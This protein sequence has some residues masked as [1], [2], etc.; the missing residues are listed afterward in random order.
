MLQMHYAKGDSLK[1][2][3]RCSV[4]FPFSGNKGDSRNLR[5]FQLDFYYTKKKKKNE[6][7][8]NKAYDR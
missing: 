5:H 7:K 4:S 2:C 3:Y 1:C 8:S 6:D